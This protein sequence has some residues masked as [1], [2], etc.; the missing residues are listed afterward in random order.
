MKMN[1]RF[2]VVMALIMV[3]ALALAGCGHVA[4]ES[5]QVDMAL[6]LVEF[7][8]AR[9]VNNPELDLDFKK[10]PGLAKSWDMSSNG[11]TWTFYLRENVVGQLDKRQ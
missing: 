2:L 10:S 8:V 4:L 7:D 3:L 1:K 9:L 5:G 11:K 6:K